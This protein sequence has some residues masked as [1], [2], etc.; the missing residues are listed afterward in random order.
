VPPA[1][2]TGPPGK[3]PGSAPLLQVRLH[4]HPVSGCLEPVA[5]LR[6]TAE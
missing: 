2:L 3:V 1:N 4:P 6:L 5:S